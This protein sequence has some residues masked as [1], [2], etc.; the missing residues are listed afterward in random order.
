MRDRKRPPDSKKL[1]LGGGG[2][3]EKEACT[4]HLPTAKSPLPRLVGNVK[5]GFSDEEQG[6][7]LLLNIATSRE[8]TGKER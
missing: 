7:Y 8:K 6:R 5:V 1:K 2:G 3:D 4:T